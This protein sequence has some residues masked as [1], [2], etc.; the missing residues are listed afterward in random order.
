[1]RQKD[2]VSLFFYS[3][4]LTL[5]CY[6]FVWLSSWLEQEDQ[7]RCSTF[8]WRSGYIIGTCWCSLWFEAENMDSSTDK[9]IILVPCEL[10]SFKCVQVLC[11]SGAWKKIGASCKRY[12]AS[13]LLYTDISIIKL[14]TISYPTS[15]CSFVGFFPGS[16]QNCEAFLRHKMTLLSPSILK[17]YGIPFEKVRSAFDLFVCP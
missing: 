9:C 5:H 6:S 1:M 12:E 3:T 13:G 14:S 8:W 7:R 10:H 11:S 16:A 15:F 2:L 17:K 4:F